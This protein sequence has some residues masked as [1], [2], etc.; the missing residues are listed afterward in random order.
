MPNYGQAGLAVAQTQLGIKEAPPGSNWGPPSK[1]ILGVGGKGPQAWCADFVEWCLEQIGWERPSFNIHYVPSWVAAAR[2]GTAGLRTVLYPAPG[3]LVA[4]DWQ[5]DSVSDHIGY[6]ETFAGA[7]PF[8]TIEGNTAFGNDS[9]GGQVMRRERYLSD[10]AAFIRLPEMPK[11]T[12]AQRVANAGIGERSIPV[13]LDR[14]KS[15]Y[16]GTVP[17]PN[18]S[19]LFRNLR[20]AGIGAANARIIVKALRD[21]R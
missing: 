18:D 16:Q 3:D 2:A 6:V 7:G 20:E 13:L 5:R 4:F 8:L 9:N 17:N 21:R 10:V 19:I 14:L 12:L 1:Y 15:G 11:L